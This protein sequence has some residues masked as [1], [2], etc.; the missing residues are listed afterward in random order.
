MTLR[1]GGHTLH[2]LLCRPSATAEI[3]MAMKRGATVL[4]PGAIM[5][6]NDLG[7]HTSFLIPLPP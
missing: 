7:L 1:R 5:H 6:W 2:F 3:A 4:E